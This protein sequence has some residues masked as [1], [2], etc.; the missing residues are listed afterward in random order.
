LR[1]ASVVRCPKAQHVAHQPIL[2]ELLSWGLS[3]DLPLHQHQRCASTPCRDPSQGTRPD[4]RRGFACSH[5]RSVLAVPPGFDGFLRTA[6]CRF[7]A[8]CS[9][10]WGS[11]RFRCWHL[12]D[13]R[14]RPP[15]SR[16]SPVESQDDRGL[17]PGDSNSFA[18]SS[19]RPL[20]P[21]LHLGPCVA[22]HA[23]VLRTNLSSTSARGWTSPIPAAAEPG[24]DPGAS[25]FPGG[26]STL[27]SVSLARSRTASLRP[28]P[29]RRCAQL[30]IS[31]VRR[32]SAPIPVHAACALDL[33]A[34]L[35]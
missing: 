11:P 28:L 29:S 9:R 14:A 19:H 34:L 30:S 23:S 3:K 35:H 12:H 33:K 2:P 24:I 25:T 18:S 1:S 10:P 27:R 20:S 7:V 13:S 4:I 16:Q 32:V 31:R 26:A 6:P 8:P 5:A 21:P 22:A 17:G 15:A